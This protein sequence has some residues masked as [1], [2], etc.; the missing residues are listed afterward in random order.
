MDAAVS[1]WTDGNRVVNNED[2]TLKI[3]YIAAVDH[4]SFFALNKSVEENKIDYFLYEK[5]K[6]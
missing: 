6:L 5:N 3:F 1:F 2:G 4:I